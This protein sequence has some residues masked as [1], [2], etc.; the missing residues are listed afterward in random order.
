MT[1]LSAAEIMAIAKGVSSKE[2]KQARAELEPGEFP[3]SG[4]F[5]VDGTLKVAEDQEIAPTASIL[6]K[7]FLVLVL[8]HAGVTREAAAK[9]ISEVANSYLVDWTG[10]KEDKKAAKAERK[11]KVAEFDPEGD[12]AAIFDDLKESLPKI[13]RAGKVTFEGAIAKAE[14]ASDEAAA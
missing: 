6:N 11:A 12:I 14:S 4:S 2:S 1:Q 7:E 9:V 8:N 13:S 5:T 10:T 3:V